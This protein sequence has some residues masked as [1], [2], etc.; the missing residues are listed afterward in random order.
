[1]ANVPEILQWEDGVYQ[2][3]TTDSAMAGADGVLNRQARA[4]ANRTAWLKNRLQS[5]EDYVIA[6]EKITIGRIYLEPRGVDKLNSGEYMLCD[7]AAISRAEYA[8]LFNAIG[9]IFGTGDG[10]STFN[11][12]LLTDRFPVFGGGKYSLN[13]KGGSENAVVVEH[14]HGGGIGNSGEHNHSLTRQGLHGTTGTTYNSLAVGGDYGNYDYGSSPL[15]PVGAHSH[16]LTINNSGESGVGK[17]LPPYVGL[18][19]VIKVKVIGL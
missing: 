19:P 8:D 10:T 15:L 18:I 5:F 3:E 13:A 11:L 7:G 9:V 2:L 6:K 12:P 16:S 4:L 17:N 1:M 14:T